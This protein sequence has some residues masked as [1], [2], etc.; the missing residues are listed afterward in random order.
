MSASRHS[1][2]LSNLP[3]TWK[4]VPIH[5]IGQVYAGGT[6]SRTNPSYWN[7]FIPWVTP[8][9]LTN[10][11]FKE[12]L[13]TRETITESGLIESSATLVPPGSLIVTT[14]ATIGNIAVAGMPLCLIKDSRT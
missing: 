10:L 4:Q 8:S 6:P 11:P 9:E 12:I 5:E 13:A 14:R 2:Y 1:E 3:T 7:G